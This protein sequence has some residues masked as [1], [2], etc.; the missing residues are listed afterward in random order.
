MLIYGDNN[1]YLT[2][3]FFEICCRKYLNTR[4]VQLQRGDELHGSD[5]STMEY[6]HE[7]QQ[8]AAS[9]GIWILMVVKIYLY[10]LNVVFAVLI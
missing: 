10:I 8:D 3:W 6:I 5:L 4:K 7:C 1:Y 2:C 9:C